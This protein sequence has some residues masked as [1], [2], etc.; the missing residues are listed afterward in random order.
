MRHGVN[1][2]NTFIYILPRV[3]LFYIIGKRVR[4]NSVSVN[5]LRETRL[6]VNRLSVN[7]L[8]ET[9]LSVNRLSV[10]RLRE[11]RLSV[12]RLSVNRLSVNHEQC[13]SLVYLSPLSLAVSL[14]PIGVRNDFQR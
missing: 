12:N 7:R 9:R 2:I 5:R 4:G 8:R 13:K 6:S 1:F 10:N 11:T 3:H 14:S